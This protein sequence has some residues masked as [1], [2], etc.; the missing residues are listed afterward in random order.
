MSAMTEIHVHVAEGEQA[1]YPEEKIPEL[2]R[3]GVLTP[4]TYYWKEG[5]TEWRLLTFFKPSSPSIVPERRTARLPDIS[6][7]RPLPSERVG[8]RPQDAGPRISSHRY[9][10][11]RKPEPLSTILQVLLILNILVA[12]L[13]LIVA[14]IR[15][16]GIWS[17]PATQAIAPDSDD[18]SW[19]LFWAGLAMNLILLIPY[20]MW[21]YRAILNCRN[22][23]TNL[24][25]T[26][27]WA[28]GCHFIPIMNLVRPYQVMQ[29]IWNVSGT[30]KT[31]Q[32]EPP[33]FLVTVWWT[34][35]LLTFGLAEASFLLRNTALDQ[36]D[37]IHA[38]FVFIA[39][40][41]I[42]ITWY[43]V[44]LSVTSQVLQRQ[45]RLVKH[46]SR[47]DRPQP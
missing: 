26:P 28:V 24:T 32:A 42:Q 17:V 37:L 20:C 2:L 18:L 6:G 9:R 10:F 15:L 41:V 45:Y 39:L 46:R 34:L 47:T 38:S 43:V 44:F 14:G 40:K 4:E 22:F 27:K 12:G 19:M 21:I 7:T 1:I 25:F 36:T 30:P 8:P 31:W 3:Q 29:A 5:M 23:S 35:C 16:A 11:R 13:E 33:S